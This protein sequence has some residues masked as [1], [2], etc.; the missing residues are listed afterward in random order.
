MT[1]MAPGK[2]PKLSEFNDLKARLQ[3]TD[4]DSL[5]LISAHHWSKW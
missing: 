4:K 3:P 2:L 1:G 5:E